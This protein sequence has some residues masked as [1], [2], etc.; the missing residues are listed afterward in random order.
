MEPIQ[1]HEEGS[2]TEEEDVMKKIGEYTCRGNMDVENTWNRIVLF[3][4]RFDTA[5]RLVEFKI[6]PRDTS[7]AANDVVAKVATDD[8][9][10]ATG[11][12]WNWQDNREIAWA[13]TENRVSFGPSFSNSTVDPDNMIVEDCYICYGHPS[14]DLLLQRRNIGLKTPYDEPFFIDVSDEEVPRIDHFLLIVPQ[15]L[16]HVPIKSLIHISTLVHG[17]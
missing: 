15:I 4:G 8:G 1:D 17:L 6:C 16:V 14:T 7:A 5:Y 2:P 10:L 12:L 3:D 13:S 9:A 11:N